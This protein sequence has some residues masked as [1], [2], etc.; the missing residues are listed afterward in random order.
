MGG[1]KKDVPVLDAEILP[2]VQP[3]RVRARIVELVNQLGENTYELGQNLY[4]VK[5]GNLY[6]EWGYGSFEEYV[7]EEVN[8]ERRKADYCI[9]IWEKLSQKLGIPW[10]RIEGIGWSKIK[11]VLPVIETRKQAETWLKKAGN[12]SRRELETLVKQ[13]QAKQLEDSGEEAPPARLPAT[14]IHHD[15][16]E[17]LEGVHQTTDAPF[18]DASVLEHAGT[19]M[20]GEDEETGEKVPLHEFKTYLFKE[21]W[22]NVMAAMERAGQLVNSDKVGHMLDVIATEFNVT[23]AE[24]SDG[25]V[26]HRLEHYVKLLE[27]LFEV[28]IE[29]TV[30]RTSKLRTMSRV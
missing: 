14:R 23:H 13:A 5:Y 9:G 10:E 21:Q 2:S 11:T 3:D 25:G 1:S 20:V 7:A 16:Q 28:Q 22:A 4:E 15:V 12:H 6:L 30:P 27:R 26:A 18:V 17:E 24:T 19:V 29:V 8:F